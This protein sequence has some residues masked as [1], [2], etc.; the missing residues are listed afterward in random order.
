MNTF[1]KK[2]KN[3]IHFILFYVWIHIWK[4]NLSSQIFTANGVSKNVNLAKISDLGYKELSCSKTSPI[5]FN[6]LQ[7]DIFIMIK[8][9]AP[10][11]SFVP[12][13][14]CINNWPIFVKLLK[15]YILNQ[16]I[17]IYQ[18]W[19]ILLKM[20][21]SFMCII[22][23]IGWIALKNFFKVIIFYLVK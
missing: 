11:S 3:L 18:T 4:A 20:T 8:Q 9:L 23:N 17:K 5:F 13:T 19:K 7:K 10:P 1:F 21:L 16:K 2:I 6:W 22:M 14:T 12:L 15:D